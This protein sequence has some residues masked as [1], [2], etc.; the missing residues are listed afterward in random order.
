MNNKS[1][2]IMSNKS[3]AGNIIIYLFGI[4]VFAVGVINAGK[5]K[6]LSGQRL[7]I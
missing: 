5:T 6:V 2:V 1:E 3:N 4:A 7:N